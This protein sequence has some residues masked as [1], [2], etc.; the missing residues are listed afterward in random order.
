M[1]R[2]PPIDHRLHIHNLEVLP[3]SN[4][5]PQDREND[6]DIEGAGVKYPVFQSQDDKGDSLPGDPEI[7]IPTTDD[8]DQQE[9]QLEA[10]ESSIPVITQPDSCT[11]CF[12]TFTIAMATQ[13]QTQEGGERTYAATGE[14]DY[15]FIQQTE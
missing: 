14:C 3:Q 2:I 8:A 9:E 10:L 7:I 12:P 6:S 13:T 11:C 4:W 15:S 5:G 1:H